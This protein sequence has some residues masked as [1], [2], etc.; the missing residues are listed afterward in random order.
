MN[1]AK[2]MKL[3]YIAKKTDDVQA[4][5]KVCLENENGRGEDSLAD[6]ACIGKGVK[7]V[8]QTILK[9]LKIADGNLIFLYLCSIIFSDFQWLTRHSV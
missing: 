1:V 5:V 4:T 6:S 8:T 9:D 3:V 7:R 2:I